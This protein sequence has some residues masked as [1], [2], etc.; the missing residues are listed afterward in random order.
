MEINVLVKTKSNRNAITLD[1]NTNIYTIYTKESPHENKANISIIEI[2]SK[3][4]KI[5]KNRIKIKRGIKSK[6]KTISIS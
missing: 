3:Q 6:N 1:K 4:L 2:I 5:P